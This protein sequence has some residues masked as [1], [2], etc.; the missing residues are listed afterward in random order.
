[1]E[2]PFCPRPLGMQVKAHASSCI[3]KPLSRFVVLGWFVFFNLLDLVLFF[4]M[5]LFVFLTVC[6]PSR[7]C[8]LKCLLWG[9]VICLGLTR[10]NLQ[11][12]PAPGS[13][14]LNGAG[15]LSQQISCF[16]WERRGL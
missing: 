12:C 14:P 3:P 7:R 13:S 16:P 1:M 8:C 15:P 2:L 4:L 11:G 6:S 9:H 10:I 5:W